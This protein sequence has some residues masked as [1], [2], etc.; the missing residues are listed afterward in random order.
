MNKRTSKIFSLF[1]LLSAVAWLIAGFRN[2][3]Q[4][5]VGLII[6]FSAAVISFILFFAYYNNFLKS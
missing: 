6:Y 3:N 5:I 4:D 1:W 2:L